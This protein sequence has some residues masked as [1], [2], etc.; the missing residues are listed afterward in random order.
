MNGAYAISGVSIDAGDELIELIKR[1]CRETK[2][3]GCISEIGG[4]GGLFDPRKAGYKDPILVSGTDGV[5]TKLLVAQMC[6]NLH[7][8]GQDLVAMC[9]NDILVH[10]AEPLFFLDYFAT[11]KLNKEVA[12]DVICGIAQGCQLANCALIGNSIQISIFLDILSFFLP[13]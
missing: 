6:K 7:S 8:I 9:V 2:R 11:G 3:D 1:P 13:I 5:G 4:F 12:K 10:G